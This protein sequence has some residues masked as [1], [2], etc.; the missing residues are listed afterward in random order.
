MGK[1]K[2]M[3]Q[4]LTEATSLPEFAKEVKAAAQ[5]FPEIG[6]MAFISDVYEGRD[7]H[8]TLEQFKKQLVQCNQQRLLSLSRAD[9]AHMYDQETVN[10]SAIQ[11]GG[12]TFHLVDSE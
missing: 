1:L 4:L 5:F 12:T 8:M 11:V 10:K 9:L 2:T 3:S 7:W 6:S